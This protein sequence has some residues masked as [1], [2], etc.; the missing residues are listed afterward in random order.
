MLA[1]TPLKGKNEIHAEVVAGT[2]I[3]GI[4]KRSELFYDRLAGSKQLTLAAQLKAV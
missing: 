1:F 2:I 3:A 4:A